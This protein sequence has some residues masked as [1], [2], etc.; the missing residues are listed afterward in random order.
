MS[1]VR[2]VGRLTVGKPHY[3]GYP[4]S[5]GIGRDWEASEPRDNS[6]RGFTPDVGGQYGWEYGGQFEYI[7]KLGCIAPMG[8]CQPSDMVL[9]EWTQLAG[10]WRESSQS[11]ALRNTWLH[12]YDGRVGYWGSIRSNAWYAPNL[13]FDFW[14][15]PGA[16]NK[17]QVPVVDIR[18]YNG[19]GCQ[20]ILRFPSQGPAGTEQSVI[21][22]ETDPQYTSPLLLGKPPTDTLWTVVDKMSLGATPRLGNAG[23][24]PIRQ[25]VRIEY[26]DGALLVRLNEYDQ[27]WAFAGNWKS[28][29]GTDVKPFALADTGQIGITVRGHTAFIRMM[30]LEYPSSAV[31][32]PSNYFFTGTGI[33]TDRNYK[34]ISH[35][36]A[37]TDITLDSI[38]I[39]N[40][41]RPEA[42]FTG[43]TKRAALYAIQEYRPGTTGNADTDTVVSGGANTDFWLQSLRGEISD[44]WRGSTCSA[45]YRGTSPGDIEII[46]P[47]SKV[48][49]AISLTDA[50]SPETT[51]F[52]GYANKPTLSRE[53][54]PNWVTAEIELADYIGARLERKTMSWHCSYEDWYI[55]DAFRQILSQAGVPDALVSVDALCEGIKLPSATM[56]G[57]RR[58]RFAPDSDVVSALDTL[59]GAVGLTS[60]AYD[61]PEKRGMTWGVNQNGL[62]RLAPAYEHVAGKYLKG[63]T[64]R[65]E[66]SDGWVIS[67]TDTDVEDMIV[68]PFT[69]SRDLSNYSNALQVMAGSGVDADTRLV[70]DSD[71]WSDPTSDQF[72][73]DIWQRFEAIPDGGDLDSIVGPM[74]RKVSAQHRFVRFSMH[75][76]PEILPEDELYF[77]VSHVD[78]AEGTI[79]RVLSKSWSIEGFTFTQSI[80]ALIVEVPS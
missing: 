13:L 32:K 35:E 51:M 41:S 75:D 21:T 66:A 42:T 10:N 80:D 11:A 5:I 78:I 49:A 15:M 37:G 52:V 9:S 17:A 54:G 72:I 20:Y 76:R 47:N 24:A 63:I 27:L 16:V 79:A 70:Y 19:G 29:E 43:G 26:L 68:A 34:L 6:L 39:A 44:T 1:Y 45:T 61:A 59:V 7:D 23:E 46:K 53:S 8:T 40:G 67:D 4:T 56:R 28:V 48:T 25:T 36:P 38:V 30:E 58:W 69:A 55:A 50:A 3:D 74:W 77:S 31:L 65:T 12:Y 64:P 62:V 22:G 57:E 73:G 60:T 71:S 33:S 18:L 2:A 14:R